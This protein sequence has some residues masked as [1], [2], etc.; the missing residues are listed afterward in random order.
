MRSLSAVPVLIRLLARLLCLSAALA[1]LTPAL[2]Q[3][4]Q[5]LT[6]NQALAVASDA[7]LFPD[8]AAARAQA[9]PDDWAQ[10]R[11]GYSGAV[12]Y[13]L[14][15]D[16]APQAPGQ[17]L[18]LYIDRACSNYQLVLNGI[19]LKSIGAMQDPISDHCYAAQLVELPSGLLKAQ[20]NVLDLH[21][22]GYARQRV[23]AVQRGGGLSA[24]EL[25]P[26]DEL[27]QRTHRTNL[28]RQGLPALLSAVMLSLALFAGAR[29][30]IS[31]RERH[32]GYLAGM[33]LLTALL[34][35]RFFV[36]EVPL[37]RDQLEWLLAS[38]VP[39]L[40]LCVVQFLLRQVGWEHRALNMALALQCLLVPVSLWW[41]GALH[42]HTL[43]G[44]WYLVLTAQVLAAMAF[45]LWLAWRNQRKEFWLMA[46]ILGL[47]GL[48]LVLEVLTQHRLVA[49]PVGLAA[50]AMPLCML[51]IGLR[52]V[53]LQAHGRNQAEL[54]R[55][56]MEQRLRDTVT[57]IERNYAQL[58]ETK[59]EQ[60]TERERKRIA[61]DLHD[62]LGA[63]LLTIVH[64]SE[65]DRISTLAREALEEMRLS[66]RGLTGKPVQLLDALGDWRAEVVS[67]LS[68]ANIV[69]E[70][71]S[72]PEDIVHTLPARAYVQT[73]R[74]FRESV[75]NIIK[76]SG[77]TH[78]TISCAV[79]GTDFQVMIQDN[80]HGISMELDGRLDRGHGMASMKSRAKQM[81]GQCLVE[82]GP[83]WGTVIRLT[84]P[85]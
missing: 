33:A 45:H 57:E 4:K 41:A 52:L 58:A 51:M 48:L 85:L 43:A 11:P 65:S 2:A 35:L 5:Y 30:L 64:T 62:D 74:I 60:V 8:G 50:V 72:P 6:L 39:P 75:S 38:L 53:V 69:A 18:G 21:L 79:L 37:P 70:W 27:T 14:G 31:H 81:H 80:G 13:R 29:A 68:Q 22:A 67:R 61:A 32:L 73:T 59:V 24:V 28:W 54:D 7:P 20:G 49:G 55:S 36:G 10:S 19:K 63:K 12:W 42:H 16:A 47:A 83:G 15:F 40:V 84:I 77:A 56:V 9:L 26:L 44:A 17:P 78:C 34:S 1:W 46:G 82:S 66:V 25:G 71:K 3:S 76:H 23:N